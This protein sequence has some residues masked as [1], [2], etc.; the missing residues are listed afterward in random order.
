MH[1][2]LEFPLCSTCKNTFRSHAESKGHSM[3]YDPYTKVDINRVSAY[4]KC[5]ML[6]V[7]Y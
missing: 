4:L 3:V 5:L 6:M 7:Y 2:K 1:I